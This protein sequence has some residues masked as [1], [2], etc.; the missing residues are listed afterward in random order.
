MA[1]INNGILPIESNYQY[2]N[3][4]KPFGTVTARQYTPT[5][6]ATGS[7]SGSIAAINGEVTPKNFDTEPTG[8]TFT[9]GKGYSRYGENMTPYLA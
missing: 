4:G 8:T 5:L 2:G 9:H 6:T 3:Y 7:I 1:P